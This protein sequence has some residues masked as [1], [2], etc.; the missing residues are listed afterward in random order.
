ME[1]LIYK[2]SALSEKTS[3]QTRYNSMLA[4]NASYDP[5]QYFY[6]SSASISTSSAS[7]TSIPS[8]YKH[9][10]IRFSG[11]NGAASYGRLSFNSDLTTTNYKTHYL[12]GNS[13]TAT[14]GGYS[15]YAGVVLAGSSGFSNPASYVIDILDYTSTNKT[16]VVRILGGTDQNGSGAIEFVS[17]V[18]LNS[19][20]AI[21][22]I[23]L[24][25]NSGSWTI[26]S[27]ALYGI[28]G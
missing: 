3:L 5:S 16:K 6:I 27:F 9:L 22:S 20:N 23:N 15:G 4:G 26:A 18:W 17:G 7:F 24:E 28:K 21:T 1:N 12:M 13:S 25:A 11:Y 2:L 8:T 14:A 10:Q 19:S